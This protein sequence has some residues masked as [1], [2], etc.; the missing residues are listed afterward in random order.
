MGGD[1]LLGAFEEHVLLSVARGEGDSYG[2]QVRRDIEARTGRDVSIGAV[3]ATLN[4]L[5]KKGLVS[6]SLRDGAPE[7]RG[8]A[9]RFFSIEAAGADALR[10]SLKQHRSMWEGLDPDALVPDAPLGG[11]SS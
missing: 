6:S 9:Q 4:R 5:E 7:R 10:Q 8:R 1:G 3:Y 11:G 2:M